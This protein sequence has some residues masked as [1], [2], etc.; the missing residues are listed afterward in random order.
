MGDFFPGL[1]LDTGFKSDSYNP[2]YTPQ[3]ID[4]RPTHLGTDDEE[5]TIGSVVFDGGAWE[6]DG[7][8]IDFIFYRSSQLEE[9]NSF[10]LNTL[11]LDDEVLDAYS[12]KRADIAVNPDETVNLDNDRIGVDHLPLI[13]D[14]RLR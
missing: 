12:L 13:A 1:A 8:T 10:I 5:R 4:V 7:S 11:I 3:M 2:S 14:F 6:V 9:H